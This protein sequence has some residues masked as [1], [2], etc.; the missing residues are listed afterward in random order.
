[1]NLRIAHKPEEKKTFSRLR[2]ETL[3]KL[4]DFNEAKNQL[5]EEIGKEKVTSIKN[6]MQLGSLYMNLKDYD[7]AFMWFNKA[8]DYGF[9]Y[10]PP[11]EGLDDFKPIRK[12]IRFESLIKKMKD[13]IG[14]EK[15]IKNF[16]E[17]DISGKLISPGLFRNSVL[18]ID[19][20]ATWCKPCREEMANLKSIYNDFNK[21]GFFIISI[22]LDSDKNALERH[23]KDF[24]PPWPIVF[25]GKGFED[26]IA[27]LYGVK[28]LPSVWVVD[29]KG[30][31]RHLFLRGKELRD[32]VKDLVGEYKDQL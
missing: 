27:Q 20:W 19:F 7:S 10:Y 14:L 13:K 6:A 5:L 2:Y 15:P 26:N 17:K 18:V 8:V 31:L 9:T 12:D 28:D 16:A 23:L 11:L 21:K 25:S 1:M 24:N 22:C 3:L 4:G 32:A 30:Y 29:R